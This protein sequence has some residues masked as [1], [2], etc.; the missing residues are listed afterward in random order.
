[1][2]IYLAKSSSCAI[3]VALLTEVKFISRGGK[4]CL[5]FIKIVSLLARNL[6]LKI[7]ANLIESLKNII[8]SETFLNCHRRSPRDFIRERILPFHTIIFLLT[9]FIKGSIQDE[10]DYFFK[11]IQGKD[12]AERTVTK[13]AFSKARKKLRH[14]AFIELDRNLLSFFYKHFPCRKWHGSRL[15]T[16]DGSTVQVPRSREV[17][18]HFGVWHPAGGGECPMARISHLHDA[19]NGV[20]VDALIRPKEQGERLLAAEHAKHLTQADL[21]LLD[22][23]Y[24]A[25]WLF[26][27]ILS[28]GAHFCSRIKETHWETVRGFCLSGKQEQIITLHPSPASLPKCREFGLPIDPIQVRI[29]RIRLDG[30]E[31][32]TLVTSLTDVNLH[33]CKIFKELYHYRWTAEENYKTAKCRVEIENFSGKTVESV[34]QDFH[35]KTFAMN[36]AAVLAHPAQDI[37]T[38]ENESKKHPYKINLTQALSKMKDSIVLLFKRDNILDLLNN[39]LNLFIKTI[40]PVR[41]DRK[42]PRNHK[43]KRGFYVCFKPIR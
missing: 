19:L 13:S 43:S 37:I 26:A 7:C 14:Q 17:A 6:L 27:L 18:E 36:L 5:N 41:P 38:A 21:I 3:F 20:I 22:R 31:T 29:I 4:L 25:F 11:A 15:L 30:G 28:K 40:E 35:A 9:N 42:Y 16:I 33:P 32:E 1:M 39:L 8:F 12:I 34:C 10:L 23:G 2:Y 24:P